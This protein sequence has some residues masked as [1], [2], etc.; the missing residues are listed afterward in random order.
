[1]CL[2]S[3]PCKLS[4][5]CHQ[6]G[7]SVNTVC[8][9]VKDIGVFN[10]GSLKYHLIFGTINLSCPKGLGCPALPHRYTVCITYTGQLL[11]TWFQTFVLHCY[12]KVK[13]VD[14]SRF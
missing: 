7:R 5:G 11:G 4:V 9:H 2:E 8:Y 12:D 6:D 13:Y 14:G 10:N 1:M 3:V